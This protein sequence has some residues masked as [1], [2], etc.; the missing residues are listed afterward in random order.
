MR[1]LVLLLSLLPVTLPALGIYTA[2]GMVGTNH[3]T[4]TNDGDGGASIIQEPNIITYSTI[5]ATNFYGD[6][7]INY[8]KEYW[9]CDLGL[10][11]MTLNLSSIKDHYSVSLPGGN[12]EGWYGTIT[13][14]GSAYGLGVYISPYA[15]IY[16]LKAG[17]SLGLLSTQGS[18]SVTDFMDEGHGGTTLGGTYI[19]SYSVS[20]TNIFY[21]PYLEI[22]TAPTKPIMLSFNVS[23]LFLNINATESGMTNHTTKNTMGLHGLNPLPYA[24]TPFDLGGFCLAIRL[25]WN[26]R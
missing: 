8:A 25:Q 23:Y 16:G 20:G 22:G 4:Y 19:Q 2:V 14:D 21:Q 10:R 24:V 13:Y 18:V 11:Y 17:L 26:S 3:Q 12:P 1:T 6:L 9:G 5:G 7:G 15:T